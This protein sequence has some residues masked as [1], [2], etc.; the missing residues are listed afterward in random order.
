MQ[1]KYNY[2]FNFAVSYVGGGLKRLYEYAKWF[3]EHGGAYFVIHP[4]CENFIS[5]FPNNRYFLATQPR[6][7]RIFNDCGY[8]DEI[9]RVI[10]KPDLYFSY[11]IPIYSK[12]G[13]VNWFHLSNVLPLYTRDIPLSFFDRYLR[14]SYLGWKIKRN[15]KHADVISAESNYSLSLVTAGEAG[16][17]FLSVNGSNNDELSNLTDLPTVAKENLALIIGTQK[18]KALMDSYYV[19]EMLRKNNDQ[20]Q[21]VIIG[22]TKSIPDDLRNRKNILIKGFVKRDEVLE[23]LRK[24]K[25]YISTTR[26]ENSSNATAEGVLFADESYI[27]DIAPHRE[28]LTNMPFDLVNIPSIGKPVLHVRRGDISGINLKTWD[29]VIVDMINKAH[30]LMPANSGHPA[31][32]C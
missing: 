7:Q 19:F 29:A 18:Y 14:L 15:F 10:G 23:N 6:Y 30:S 25:Y 12:F 4:H 17:L 32:S 5:E 28:W 27:S 20:L 16:K 3:N 26:I 22:D 2:L 1:L 21:L 9:G 13:H 31:R 24:T 11:G 8:L